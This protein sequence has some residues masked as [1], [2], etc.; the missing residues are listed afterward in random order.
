MLAIVMAGLEAAFDRYLRLEPEIWLRLK[1]LEGKVIALMVEGV[2]H[3]FYLLI[4]ADH[5][6]VVDRYAD[7]P[8][9]VIRGSWLALF[10]AW[11][12]ADPSVATALTIE[13][14]TSVAHQFQG[15]MATLDIDWEEQLSRA[16]GDVAA[17]SLGS[18]W[19]GVQHWKQRTSTTWSRNSTE[20]LQQE[21]QALPPR[22]AVE[23]FLN[24]VDTLREDADRLTV[25]VERLRRYSV[26]G[27]VL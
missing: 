24:A 2:N 8:S 18:L 15:I 20:Y 16:V 7:E 19:R 9:V 12:A 5:I 23:Q 13:G 22:H 25:R 21:L 14:D 27:D 1:P 3:P 11:Q 17:H 26:I 4:K 10:K 6:R